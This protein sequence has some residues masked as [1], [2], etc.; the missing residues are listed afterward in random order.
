MF[1]TKFFQL[2]NLLKVEV[3]IGNVETVVRAD[4]TRTAPSVGYDSIIVSVTCYMTGQEENCSDNTLIRL[5][6]ME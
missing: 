5:I 3:A 6:K 2:G 4:R 1:R